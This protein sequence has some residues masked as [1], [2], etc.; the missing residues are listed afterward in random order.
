MD[1][2]QNGEKIRLTG[3]IADYENIS[4]Y[5]TVTGHGF[6]YITKAKL[7]AKSLSIN[8]AGRTKVTINGIGDTGAYSYSMTPKTSSTVYVIRAWAS[9]TNSSGKTVYVYSDPI[10]VNYDNLATQ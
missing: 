10:Y 8:T 5:Y 7:G 2:S 6:V 3:S 9:Y 4:D 1:A